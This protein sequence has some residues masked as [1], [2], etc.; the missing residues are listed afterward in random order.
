MK[1][2]AIGGTGFIG[3]F[4]AAYLQERGHSPLLSGVLDQLQAEGYI[5][6]VTPVA[7]EF[8]KGG[9]EMLRVLKK[10]LV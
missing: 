2:L 10:R 6:E 8:Q 5:V 9:N 1:I 4:V 7:Y 3:P